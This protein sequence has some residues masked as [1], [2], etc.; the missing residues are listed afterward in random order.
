MRDVRSWDGCDEIAFIVLHVSACTFRSA[1]FNDILVK[2]I[3]DH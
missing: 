3:A 1:R 2:S